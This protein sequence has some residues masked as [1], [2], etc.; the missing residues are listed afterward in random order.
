MSYRA[1]IPGAAGTEV[2]FESREQG[3]AAMD[4]VKTS[5]PLAGALTGA[6]IVVG[7]GRR[8]VAGLVTPAADREQD[9]DETDPA[10]DE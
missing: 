9:R 8:R 1:R 6:P 3:R 4:A 5:L 2:D 10:C 7:A